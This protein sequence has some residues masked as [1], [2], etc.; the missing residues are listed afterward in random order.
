MIEHCFALSVL[1]DRV[2]IIKT[3]MKFRSILN[4]YHLILQ[5]F[6]DYYNFFFINIIDFL[7]SQ[8]HLKITNLLVAYFIWLHDLVANLYLITTKKL[9]KLKYNYL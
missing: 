1:I 6:A 4:Y 3:E 9:I 2:L 8:I 5:K 7:N